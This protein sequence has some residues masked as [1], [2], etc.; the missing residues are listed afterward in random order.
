MRFF[1]ARGPWSFSP[2]AASGSRPLG[3]G[4][5]QATWIAALATAPVA[6]VSVRGTPLYNG[7]RHLLFVL[8]FL[9]VVA[10]LSVA[11]WWESRPRALLRAAGVLALA[12]SLLLTTVDMVRLHPYQYVFFNRLVAGGLPRAVDRYDADYWIAA[13]KE[14]I[15]WVAAHYDEEEQPIRVGGPLL[16]HTPF[17]YYLGRIDGGLRR[18]QPVTF[19]EGPRLVLTSTAYRHHE[20]AGG[21]VVHVVERQGAPLLYVYDVR[22]P[23]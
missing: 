11:A 21:K 17:R 6:W 5:L 22:L 23:E 8:P 2:G 16:T 13:A 14:G 3:R 10:G 19:D 20:E 4:L 1:S 9:A 7:H 15:E 12:A 18:F